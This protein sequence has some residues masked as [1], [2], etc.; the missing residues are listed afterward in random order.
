M[1][2]LPEVLPLAE[3][4]KA[5]SCSTRTLRRRISEGE[6][7]ASQVSDRGGWVVQRGDLLAFLDARAT[8]SRLGAGIA[9]QPAPARRLAR[10]GS[11]AGRLT[12]TPDMGRAG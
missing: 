8:R 7:R 4:A 5:L 9:P 11:H 3:A 1:D 6:L 12:V 10:G 2:D